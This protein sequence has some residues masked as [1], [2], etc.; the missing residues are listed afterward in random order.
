[1]YSMRRKNKKQ[2]PSVHSIS[3]KEEL[4]QEFA[5]NIKY[6]AQRFIAKLPASV[7]I[8]DLVD[9]G[10]IGLLDAA[11]KFDESRGIQFKT[12]AEYRIRGAMLD[13]LRRNDWLPRSVRKKSNQ[14]GKVYKE[15]EK[16]LKRPPRAEEIAEVLGME[17]E[18]YYD[19]LKDATTGSVIQLEEL[20]RVVEGN[21]G[22]EE[23]LYRL[24]KATKQNDPYL[25]VQF[26]DLIAYISKFIEKLPEKERLVITLYYYEE[27]TMKEIGY[28]LGITES[29]VS[30]LRSQAIMRLR[31]WAKEDE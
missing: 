29:R 14:I 23:H 9:A 28:I 30:Q 2:H 21:T 20:G 17:M 6:I 11:E 19:F 24:V 13:E 26:K 5:P 22:W 3:R 7:E 27:L 15:L 31:A 4:I 1:M 18:E 12:Y 16:K 10:V 25:S 8:G